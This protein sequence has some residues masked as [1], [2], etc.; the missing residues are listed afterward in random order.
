MVISALKLFLDKRKLFSC[1]LGFVLCQ[2]FANLKK[3]EVKRLKQENAVVLQLG[4][5][6]YQNNPLCKTVV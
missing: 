2:I 1:Y 6:R 3:N 4:Y 5:P